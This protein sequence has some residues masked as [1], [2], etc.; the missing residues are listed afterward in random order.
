[1]NKAAE[2]KPYTEDVPEIRRI[3]LSDLQF[4]D[5]NANQGTELGKDLLQNSITKYGIGRGV[6]ADKN[7]KLI[8]G[9]HAVKEMMEQGV[10]QVIVIPTDGRTLVVTQR[11]D[12]DKDSKEGHGLALA[13]N[14]VTQANLNFDMSV[15]RE[16]DAEFDLDM[17]DLGIDI[18]EEESPFR[19][20]GYQATEEEEN[21]AT[22]TFHRENVAAYTGNEEKE[23]LQTLFPLAVTLTKAEKIAFDNWKKENG[24]RTDTEGFCLLFKKIK[25]L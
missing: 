2:N 11:V 7:L 6:L 9:N 18:H 24:T 17:Q 12:I 14:R 16:L 22:G 21:E 8:A 15:I 4:D 20:H 23:F 19:G 3:K 10:E 25:E 13:D 5:R 1:M